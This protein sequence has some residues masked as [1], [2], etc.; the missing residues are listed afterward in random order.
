M[1]TAEQ[2][3]L[4]IGSALAGNHRDRRHLGIAARHRSG[5]AGPGTPLSATTG[6]SHDHHVGSTANGYR[7]RTEAAMTIA[8]APGAPA[9]TTAGLGTVDDV[10]LAS[11]HEQGTTA[12]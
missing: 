12:C 3:V 1:L 4:E 5:R 6:R 11:R 7:C 10:G 8:L 9:D 2:K